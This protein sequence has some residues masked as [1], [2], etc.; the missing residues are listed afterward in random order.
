MSDP[1][2]LAHLPDALSFIEC[3]ADYQGWMATGALIAAASPDG[4]GESLFLEWSSRGA[5]FNER[6]A[7]AKWR[8][9]TRGHRRKT[10]EEAT[11]IL[12]G[13]AHKAGWRRP[14]GEPRPRRPR[15]A[16]QAP[17]QP[18]GPDAR[19]LKAIAS[20]QALWAEAKPASC[21]LVETYLRARNLHLPAGA[22]GL[23]F[24]PATPYFEDGRQTG[25]WPA[26]LARIE[27]PDGQTIGVHRTHLHPSGSRKAPV[28]APKKILGMSGGGFITVVPGPRPV[29]SEGI[30]SGLAALAIMTAEAER[31]HPRPLELQPFDDDIGPEQVEANRQEWRAWMAAMERGAPSGVI[32][33]ISAGGMEGLPLPLRWL[34]APVGRMWIAADQDEAGQRAADRLGIRAEEMGI[35]YQIVEPENDGE[36]FADLAA[37]RRHP[38]HEDEP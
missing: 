4:W 32:A 38:K 26:M 13:M 7:R 29:V 21:T 22:T 28:D 27:N 25:K 24:H 36:D 15:F 3:P 11:D 10:A 18:Q 5:G 35:A 19:Q 34:G 2:D 31:R 33:A 9:L 12:L 30:E 20:A 14:A 16:P 1:D 23:R 8:D 37:R 6:D 17:P